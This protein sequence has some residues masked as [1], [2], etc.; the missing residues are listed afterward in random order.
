[1]TVRLPIPGSDDG[2]WGTILNSF[3][4]VSHNDDGT[5]KVSAL[6]AAGVVTSINSVTPQNGNIDVSPSAIGA[7]NKPSTGI[8]VSDLESSVQ[9]SLQVASALAPPPGVAVGSIPVVTG[10]N[11]LTTTW[12]PTVDLSTLGYATISEMDAA[13]ASAGTTSL[14]TTSLIGRWASSDLSGLANGAAITTWAAN[15]SA[16]TGTGALTS[17]YSWLQP[18]YN[19]ST[20]SVSGLPAAVFN[21]SSMNAVLSA[22]W[23]SSTVYMVM[24]SLRASTDYNNYVLYTD[25]NGVVQPQISPAVSDEFIYQATSDPTVNVG[26]RYL[27]LNYPVRVSI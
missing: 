25:T 13:I 24:R 2:T 1:M 10:T 15:A 22:D 19:D 14:P 6:Q 26:W 18:I 5:P 3:L 20:H 7:Y 16:P 8:P 11:P 23:S 12:L 17:L 4:D 21:A 27:R 9:S